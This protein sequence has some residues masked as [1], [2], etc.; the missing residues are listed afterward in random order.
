MKRLFCSTKILFSQAWF[1]G[2]I[3]DA[4]HKSIEFKNVG[5]LNCNRRENC[6]AV[7]P[8]TALG[9]KLFQGR[10]VWQGVTEVLDL[11]NRPKARPACAWSHYGGPRHERELFVAVGSPAIGFSTKRPVQFEIVKGVRRKK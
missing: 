11:R 6:E 7:S 8:E 1:S 9:H 3:G 10:K 2:S 5:V 4:V